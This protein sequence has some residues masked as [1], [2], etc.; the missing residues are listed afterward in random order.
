MSASGSFTIADGVYVGVAS[1]S[2]DAVA[3][4]TYSSTRRR[5]CSGS[6]DDDV[7]DAVDTV[8]TVDVVAAGALS[9]LLLPPTLRA[10][11]T[12]FGVGLY[13]TAATIFGFAA[14]VRQ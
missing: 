1:S 11:K 4:G 6:S 9:A 7:I 13:T 5:F 12:A 14:S 3:F 2:L 10:S 8:D